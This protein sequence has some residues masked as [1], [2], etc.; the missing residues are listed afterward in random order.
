MKLKLKSILFAILLLLLIANKSV[1]SQDYAEEEAD[2]EADEEVVENNKNLDIIESEI[3]V[4]S[5]KTGINSS[6]LQL[7]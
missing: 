1:I 7:S 4:N 3:E 2:E 6:F 5:S